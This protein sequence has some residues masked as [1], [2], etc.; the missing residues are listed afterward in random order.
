MYLREIPIIGDVIDL[1]Y[2]GL[3]DITEF[4]YYHLPNIEEIRKTPLNIIIWGLLALSI[5]LFFIYSFFVLLIIS[6]CVKYLYIF[7]LYLVLIS[8]LNVINLKPN[9]LIKSFLKILE[10]ILYKLELKL[11]IKSNF[12]SDENKLIVNDFYSLNEK[13]S[14]IK[15][16]INDDIKN[17]EIKKISEVISQE[18][19]KF[20]NL[21]NPFE[22]YKNQSE[23]GTIKNYTKL[24]LIKEILFFIWVALTLFLM[25]T[26][27]NIANILLG[28]DDIMINVVMNNQILD[29]VMLLVLVWGWLMG[30][31]FYMFFK[32]ITSVDEVINF[33]FNFMESIRLKVPLKKYINTVEDLEEE[34]YD[35]KYDKEIKRLRKESLWKIIKEIWKIKIEKISI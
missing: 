5:I 30:I 34:L 17:R 16:N 33:I 12:S 26:F 11:D 31:P 21:L 22:I 10:S 14:E 27:L 18:K 28:L 24:I 13:I 15:K 8:Y 3:D 23:W 29:A 32:W 6:L 2:E 9:I 20:L 1:F 35:I 25:Y 7:I 4:F 19:Y